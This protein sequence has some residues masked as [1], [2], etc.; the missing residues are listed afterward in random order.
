VIGQRINCATLYSETILETCSDSAINDFKE[1]GCRFPNHTYEVL[2]RRVD[3]SEIRIG[4]SHIEA[5]TA[6]RECRLCPLRELHPTG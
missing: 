2:W 5:A 4:L 1:M 6:G 3:G